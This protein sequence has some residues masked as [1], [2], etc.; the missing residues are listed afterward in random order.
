MADMTE[1]PDLASQIAI[2][3][4]EAAKEREQAAKDRE[5]AAK[6]HEQLEKLQ[7]E[8]ADLLVRMETLS[9]QN[10]TDP[11]PPPS[12]FRVPISPMQSL[13]SLTPNSSIGGSS[14]TDPPALVRNQQTPTIV[15]NTPNSS[16]NAGGQGT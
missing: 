2:L 11:P 13:G 8:N 12:R 7:A 14:Q 6:D 5:Q 1:I 4:A 16:I 15:T 10:M 9:S 3:T